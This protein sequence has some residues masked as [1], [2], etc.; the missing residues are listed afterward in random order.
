MPSNLP[1]KHRLTSSYP[2]VRGCQ[3]LH[4]PRNVETIGSYKIS[5]FRS[6]VDEDSCSLGLRRSMDRLSS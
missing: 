5:E 6:H 1:P 4:T 2:Y 3:A